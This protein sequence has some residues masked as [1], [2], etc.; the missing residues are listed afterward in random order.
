MTRADRGYTLVELMVACSLMPIFAVAAFSLTHHHQA[1]AQRHA[2]YTTDLMECRAALSSIV[3]DLRLATRVVAD[4][5]SITIL[6]PDGEMRYELT[7]SRL[8]RIADTRRRR[9]GSRVAALRCEVIGG[10]VHV[11]L[12]LARRS[13]VP[14]GKPPT[15]EARVALRAGA[16]R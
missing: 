7:G 1:A 4:G 14:S 13:N 8:D 11:A 3:R 10:L 16:S 2:A 5:S 15:L 6:G 12:T 9:L